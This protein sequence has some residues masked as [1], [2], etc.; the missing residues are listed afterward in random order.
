MGLT[1]SVRPSPRLR[2]CRQ[3][4]AAAIEEFAPL[5]GHVTTSDLQG[6]CD[7]RAMRIMGTSDPGVASV[8]S[9][10][11]IDSIQRISIYGGSV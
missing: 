1:F 2:I 5:I 3:E 6:I 7:A 10:L 9:D 11:I 4:I 8:V